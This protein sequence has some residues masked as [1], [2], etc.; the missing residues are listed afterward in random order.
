MDLAFA[1]AMASKQTTLTIA[2]IFVL[3]PSS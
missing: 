2:I 3:N 1:P